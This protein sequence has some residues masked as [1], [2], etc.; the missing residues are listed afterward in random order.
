MKEDKINEAVDVA[1]FALF[2]AMR[3]V[4]NEGNITGE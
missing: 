3:H 1:N 4:D 2:F